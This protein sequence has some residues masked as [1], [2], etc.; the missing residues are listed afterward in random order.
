MNRTLKNHI[1][2]GA[3]AALAGIAMPASAETVLQLASVESPQTV[4]GQV[5]RK[6][7]DGVAKA[8][9]GD[10]KIELALSGSTGSVRETLEALTIG[11]NDVVMTVVAALNSYDS[12]AALESYPYLIRDEEHFN[13]VYNG[14]IGSDLFDAL[15]QSSGLRLVGAG[16]RGPREMASKRAINSVEDLSGLKI[17][18]P[19]ID[20]FRETWST[21]GA[22]PT[23]MSSKEVYT[24]LQSGIID[25]VENPLSAHIRSKYHEAADYVILTHHVYGA[26]TF[27]FDDA[28]FKSLTEAQQAIVAEQAKIAFEW[29]TETAK[30]QL[31]DLRATLEGHG[32]TFI[33]PDL[34]MFRSKL[35]PMAGQ[36]PD[37]APWVERIQAA[38]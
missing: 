29:G 25:A 8:S 9:G 21:L 38:K 20:V 6:F 18:V 30:V 19:G 10:L 32:A 5:A 12:L 1:V 36:F 14:E 22:S 3:L 24:G 26:Y 35:V 28:R 4:W 13:T 33:E 7:A 37:L 15:A 31:A 23:P 17:R 11:T 34:E 2:A 16:S 27:V